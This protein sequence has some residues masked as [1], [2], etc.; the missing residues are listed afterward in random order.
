M[1]KLL[2][3]VATGLRI[4]KALDIWKSGAIVYE[5]WL[6]DEL[7]DVIHE[8]DAKLLGIL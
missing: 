3:P 1:F 5:L 7:I 2:K 6:E 4:V 8:T